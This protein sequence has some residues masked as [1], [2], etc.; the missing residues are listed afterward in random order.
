MKRLSMYDRHAHDSLLTATLRD[1]GSILF[2]DGSESTKHI[3]A[4][5]AAA[6][7]W[8]AS[9]INAV[10]LTKY[11]GNHATL[12]TKY[13]ICIDALSTNV[14][15]KLTYDVFYTRGDKQVTMMN[16][17]NF[18]FHRTFSNGETQVRAHSSG[19]VFSTAYKYIDVS[20]YPFIKSVH[21]MRTS[22]HLVC[23]DGTLINI[24]VPDT[25]LIQ[26]LDSYDQANWRK[27]VNS[28]IATRYHSECI[29]DNKGNKA[30]ALKFYDNDHT[31]N[32]YGNDTAAGS[33]SDV[34]HD[35]VFSREWSYVIFAFSFILFIAS[36]Y[37][38][39]QC[40]GAP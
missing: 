21:Y 24:V 39:N 2:A 35:Y 31:S 13:E 7:Y 16:G 19:N 12:A 29:S 32:C 22:R 6:D 25:L 9:N 14:P 8:V 27:D 40:V 18:W 36:S 23:I 30:V 17:V 37:F 38:F 4:G 15:N 1:D 26:W 5:L 28:F 3:D 11:A 10:S 34:A 20:N 33:S